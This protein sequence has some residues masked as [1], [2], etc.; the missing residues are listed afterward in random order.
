MEVLLAQK[1]E[2]L[3]KEGD[4]VKVKDGYAR[5]YL[6]PKK[7]ALAITK[8]TRKQVDEQRKH[9]VLSLERQEKKAKEIKVKIESTSLTI[10]VKAGEN[11]KIFGSVTNL[12]IQKELVEQGIKIDKKKI[13]VEEPIQSLGS[14]EIPVKLTADIEAIL[15]VAVVKS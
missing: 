8:G 10:K 7:L 9:L 2:K 14:Y 3:G 13:F 12:L 11:N 15:Q 4:V 6:L 1:V 5:N